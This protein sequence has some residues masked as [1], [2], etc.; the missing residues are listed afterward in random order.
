[1]RF[2]TPHTRRAKKSSIAVLPF[3]VGVLLAVIV[4]GRSSQV[5]ASA[6]R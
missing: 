5:H 3:V 1:M 6:R 2:D 4:Y